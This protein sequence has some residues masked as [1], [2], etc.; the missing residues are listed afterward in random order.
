MAIST[1]A[2]EQNRFMELLEQHRCIAGKV[3]RTYSEL[4]RLWDSEFVKSSVVDGADYHWLSKL[5]PHP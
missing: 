3:A 4:K 1:P 5:S 2:D